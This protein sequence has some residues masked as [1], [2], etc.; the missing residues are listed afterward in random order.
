MSAAAAQPIDGPPARAPSRWRRVRRIAAWSCVVLSLA[1]LAVWLTRNEWLAP[2][3]LRRARPSLAE[4]FGLELEVGAFRGTWTDGLVLENV[5]LVASDERG[6]L[7][8]FEAGAVTLDY[9]MVRLLRGDL[10]GLRRVEARGVRVELDVDASRR[11]STASNATEVQLPTQWPELV[12]ADLHASLKLDA[13]RSIELERTQARLRGSQVGGAFELSVG[14]L[15]LAGEWPLVARMF[16]VE[17]RGELAGA[18]VT[19]SSIEVSGDLQLS[20]GRGQLALDRV[21]AGEL[22]W[23]LAADAA[24]GSLVLDA[25]HAREELTLDFEARELDAATAYAWLRGDPSPPI[26]GRATLSGE[27]QNGANGLWLWTHARLSDGCVLSQP[28]DALELEGAFTPREVWLAV[29]SAREGD[30]LLTGRGLRAPLDAQA[31]PERLRAARGE[32]EL[33]ARDVPALV[34]ADS[35]AAPPHLFELAGRLD[36]RGL[37]LSGG[38][39]RTLDAALWLERGSVRWGEGADD[40]LR[41]AELELTALADFADLS[42]LGALIGA[43]RW[44]GRG[45]GVVS[46]SGPL[47]EPRGD[48]DLIG[49]NI[50][51]GE[52]QLGE[53]AVR[54]QLGAGR[55]EIAELRAE[56]E[57]GELELGGEV[58]LLAKQLRDVRVRFATRDVARVAEAIGASAVSQYVSAGELK[59]EAHCEGA[60]LDP[61]GELQLSAS[62]VTASDGRVFEELRVSVQRRRERWQVEELA[63]RS[64]EFSA[65]TTGVVLH[66]LRATNALAL[67]D[68]LQLSHGDAELTLVRPGTLAWNKGSIATSLLEL[69]GSAGGATLELRVAPDEA[70]IALSARELQPLAFLAPFLPAGAECA[71]ARGELELLRS[72]VGWSGHADLELDD[73]RWD[74]SWPSADLALAARGDELAVQIER[75]VLDAADAGHLELSGAA[76]RSLARPLGFAS[77]SATALGSVSAFELGRWPWSELGLELRMRG[78]LDAS[79]DLTLRDGEPGGSIRVDIAD[80]AVQPPDELALGAASQLR[81]LTVALQAHFDGDLVVDSCQIRAPEQLEIVASARLGSAARWLAA[82]GDSPLPADAALSVQARWS[83]G[84]LRWLSNLTPA[85]RRVEGALSGDLLASGTWGQPRAEGSWAWSRGA[86]RLGLNAPPFERVEAR[87]SMAG[88]RLS[89]ESLRGELGGGPFELSGAIDLA[90]PGELDLVLRGQELLVLRERDLRARADADLRLVGTFAAPLLSGTIGARDGRWRQRIEWLPSAPAPVVARRGGELPFTI[91]GGVLEGLRYDL[92]I[93][94][95]GDFVIETNLGTINLRP[96]LRLRGRA[97]APTLEGAIFLDPTRISLPGSTLDLRAGTIL[98]DA[99]APTTPTIDA[100]ATARVLGYDITARVSGRSDALERELTSSPPLRSEDISVL[101]LTGR[102]PRDLVGNESG[103]DAA[104]TVI[105]FLGKDLLSS[106]TG[107]A[108]QLTERL[109]WRAGTDATRTGGSTAQVSVR[110]AGPATGPGS[111]TYLRGERDVYDRINYGLRWVVRLK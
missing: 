3:L 40:W 11:A 48:L 10:G 95:A 4:R 19:A 45:S 22:A 41:E 7:R 57:L 67:L 94:S 24:G 2:W 93:E 53:V 81:D 36:E 61:D 97:D 100:T 21:G 38:R 32:F 103:V 78:K 44:T 82:F 85:L 71:A 15:Q 104:Q 87:G 29:L 54:A 111:A 96:A 86:L 110:V 84:D 8:R 25:R 30:N 52:L 55:L 23:E 50:A 20:N 49:E 47:R 43:P 77:A 18:C 64:G 60:W 75:L 108:S 6:S 5:R 42:R 102:V 101:L 39:L 107:G 105:L 80:L 92:A 51:F 13:K 56:S 99:F 37:E 9:E 14:A 73:A 72:G 106:W 34:R 79:F 83:I 90:G 66:E 74:E 26:E 16:S 98:F 27:L 62:S 35:A 68:T 46:I 65:R 89:I 76:E 69:A 70:R 28:V 58:E 31:W 12:L 109:E 88:S 63:A 33:V 91:H 59:V 1:L 17:A